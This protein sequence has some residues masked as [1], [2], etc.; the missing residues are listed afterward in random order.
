[1]FLHEA[2]VQLSEEG[3]DHFLDLASGLPTEEHIHSTEP[4]A[5]VIYVDNDP[6]VVAFGISQ[7]RSAHRPG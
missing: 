7:S 5:K 4:D 1:M 3:F 6:V 2:V